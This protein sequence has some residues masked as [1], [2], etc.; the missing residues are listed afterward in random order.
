[1]NWGTFFLGLVSGIFLKV[2]GEILNPT[3]AELG[4]KLHAKVWRKP[5]IRGQ[6]EE[7]LSILE[8]IQIPL[9]SINQI[10]RFPDSYKKTSEWLL[11]IDTKARKLQTMAFQDIKGKL[12]AF[13]FSMNQVSVNTRL[14]TVLK[15]FVK[16]EKAFKLVEEIRRI[17]SKTLKEKKK[18]SK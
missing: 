17:I 15:L 2:L 18:K 16:D 9:L 11:D 14:D 4:A 5:Y 1:M 7:D 3:L 13:T 8:S 10:P 6:L 12:L